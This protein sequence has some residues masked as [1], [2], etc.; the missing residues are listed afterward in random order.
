MPTPDEDNWPSYRRMILDR[1]ENTGKALVEVRDDLT[2]FRNEDMAQI[3][4][5]VA[6]LKFQLMFLTT[7]ASIGVTLVMNVVFHFWK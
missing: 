6:L 2:K 7:G 1:L 3:K 5:D 4:Q